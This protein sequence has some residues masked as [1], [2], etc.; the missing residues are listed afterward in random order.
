VARI[1]LLTALALSS[2]RG[3]FGRDKDCSCGLEEKRDRLEKDL[4]RGRINKDEHDYRERELKHASG[5][6]RA[7]EK[8][9]NRGYAEK[10]D[11][12]YKDY[13]RGRISREEYERKVDRLGAHL[14]GCPAYGH[15]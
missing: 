9:C 15:H 10:F 13:T 7:E 11:R 4:R 5:C 2:T 14:G 6:R 12:L 8:A 1:G 3:E